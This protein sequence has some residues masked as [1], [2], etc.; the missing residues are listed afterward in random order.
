[1]QD[2]TI[3]VAE[4][5]S[6]IQNITKKVLQFQNYNLLFAKNGR[7]VLDLL[8]ENNCDVILMDI[9]MPIMDG[10]ECIKTIRSAKGNISKIPVI[11]VT[12]NVKN[13]TEEE[14]KAFGFNDVIVKPIDFDLLLRKTEQQMG[15]NA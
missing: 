7:D 4:D 2:K 6:V 11:A 10:V 9:T 13:Y 1:M 5:S 3:L 15:I 12:G 8:K 14:F